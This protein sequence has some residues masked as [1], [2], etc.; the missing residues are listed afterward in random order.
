[1]A[2]RIPV[3]KWRDNQLTYHL[4]ERNI[5]ESLLT[6]VIYDLRKQYAVQGWEGL[7]D[8]EEAVKH[9]LSE[10]YLITDGVNW[11]GYDVVQPWFLKQPIL[12]E[13]FISGFHVKEAVEILKKVAVLEDCK[14]V[15]VGTRAAPHGRHLGLAKMYSALGLQ[16][17]TIELTAEVDSE[18]SS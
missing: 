10:V 8:V 9:V 17:S 14:R 13:E 4:I 15:V 16:I 12:V 6:E 18:Q 11:L 7:Q 5:L 1:M 2:E 3:L